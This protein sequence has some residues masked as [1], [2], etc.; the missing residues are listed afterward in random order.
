M[1]VEQ[2]LL[3]RTSE[4]NDWKLSPWQNRVSLSK[5]ICNIQKFVCSFIPHA[6]TVRNGN[7]IFHMCCCMWC[8]FLYLCSL[9]LSARTFGRIKSFIHY[10][11]VLTKV[12]LRKEIHQINYKMCGHTESLILVNCNLFCQGGMLKEG[13]HLVASHLGITHSSSKYTLGCQGPNPDL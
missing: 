4:V 7:I 2:I 1:Q 9:H 6:A 11:Y 3:F 5:N 13:T 10:C 8:V 12:I